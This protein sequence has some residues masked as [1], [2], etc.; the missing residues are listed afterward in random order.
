VSHP[1]I[2]IEI[3]GSTPRDWQPTVTVKQILLAIQVLDRAALIAATTHFVL[4]HS[5]ALTYYLL[6]LAL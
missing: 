3:V 2:E 1:L 5:I 6:A 4:L